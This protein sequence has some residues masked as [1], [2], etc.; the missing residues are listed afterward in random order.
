MGLVQIGAGHHSNVT[1]GLALSCVDQKLISV[2]LLCASQHGNEHRM[3][4]CLSVVLK[5]CTLAEPLG[6][7]FHTSSEVAN[8]EM[9]KTMVMRRRKPLVL[10]ANGICGN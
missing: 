2:P 3:V 7:G 1:F 9:A 4:T 5:N 10:M 6:I 8:M